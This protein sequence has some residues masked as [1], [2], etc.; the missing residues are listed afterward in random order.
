M[1]RV[2]LDSFRKLA[3][4]IRSSLTSVKEGISLVSDGTLGEVN[5]KQKKCLK[6]AERGIAAVVLLANSIPKLK[7]GRRGKNARCKKNIHC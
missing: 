3:H 5:R 1:R 2:K 4:D 7:K 6:I